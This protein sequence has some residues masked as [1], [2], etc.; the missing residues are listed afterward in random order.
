MAATGVVLIS[1][2]SWAGDLRR[3]AQTG[4]NREAEAVQLD[5]RG[6]HAQAQTKAIGV[7]IVV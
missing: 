3:A 4:H 7:S 2:L 6:D 1:I 5:D